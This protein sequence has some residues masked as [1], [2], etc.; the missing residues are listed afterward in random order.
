MIKKLLIKWNSQDETEESGKFWLAAN[1]LC[2]EYHKP[3]IDE[4]V[5]KEMIDIVIKALY[6]KYVI[7]SLW[8]WITCGFKY[9]NMYW[10]KVK[11]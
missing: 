11:N 8:W 6:K 9:N 5:S 3:M 10:Y 4:L 1:L 7:K 2:H